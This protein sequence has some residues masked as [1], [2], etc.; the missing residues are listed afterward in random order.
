M[1]L[2]FIAFEVAPL[3]YQACRECVSG[4]F[5][6]L[7]EDD[8]ARPSRD[9]ETCY[10]RILKVESAA[11]EPD[12]DD[13]STSS[14]EEARELDE[15]GC[16]AVKDGIEM[17]FEA[18]EMVASMDR[19]ENCQS[20]KAARSLDD[21]DA[22]LTHKDAEEP[23]DIEN[24]RIAEEAKEVEECKDVKEAKAVEPAHEEREKRKQ[25][26]LFWKPFSSEQHVAVSRKK[27]RGTSKAEREL[28]VEEGRPII[29]KAEQERLV[30]EACSVV[31]EADG[32]ILK[33]ME[34]YGEWTSNG[35]IRRLDEDDAT[36]RRK[37]A[38]EERSAKR[39]VEEVEKMKKRLLDV[40]EKVKKRADHE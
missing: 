1:M 17:L 23:K 27:R 24:A 3:L 25:W 39:L 33:E 32:Y 18:L 19:C 34:I 9:A 29:S 36:R 38:E 11:P 40:A 13:E 35:V 28:S 6:P 22:T 15:F 7:R 4:A 31:S 21:D 37:D 10:E 26:S 20:N 8:T 5:Q 2:G 12:D 14:Y 16:I 30:E